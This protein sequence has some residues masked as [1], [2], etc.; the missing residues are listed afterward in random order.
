MFDDVTKKWEGSQLPIET[1]DQR[2][3]LAA[4]TIEMMEEKSAD[5][6]GEDRFRSRRILG[7]HKRKKKKDK[8]WSEPG[9]NQ[10][11]N[12][13]KEKPVRREN[14]ECGHGKIKARI[15]MIQ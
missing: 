3:D 12:A 6:S 14:P 13:Q 7:T 4:D 8:K 5:F 1:G 2:V 15:D 10:Q 11:E 9:A